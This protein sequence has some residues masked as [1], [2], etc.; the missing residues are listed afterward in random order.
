MTIHSKF[1]DRVT[2]T[3]NRPS[4]APPTCASCVFAADPV[5]HDGLLYCRRYPP[6]VAAHYD[7]VLDV[8][9]TAF[10]AVSAE[11]SCGEWHP[12]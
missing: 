9:P 12:K 10:P 8:A 7:T 11:E 5:R 4:A 1:I 3:D 2:G 6:Q